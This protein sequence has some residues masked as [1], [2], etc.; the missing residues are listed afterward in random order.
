MRYNAGEAAA[1]KITIPRGNVPKV[2]GTHAAAGREGHPAVARCFFETIDMESEKRTTRN[3]AEVIRRKMANDPE[4]AAAI[5]R[6]L[7]E[8]DAEIEAYS[9]SAGDTEGLPQF[10]DFSIDI[11]GGIES[12]EFVRGLRDD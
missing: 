7:K 11:T 9:R 5:R 10:K 12:S 6:E 4:L 8:A 3:F 1:A 2:A